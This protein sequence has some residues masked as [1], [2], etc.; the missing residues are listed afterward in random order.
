[1]RYIFIALF[2]VFLGCVETDFKFDKNEWMKISNQQDRDIRDYRLHRIADQIVRSNFLVGKDR[3]EV[4][5]L[6][7]SGSSRGKPNRL[8]YPLGPERGLGVD[9][10]WLEVNFEK[11]KVISSRVVRY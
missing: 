3:E 1:M 11:D 7:G 10:E 9:Y 5:S 6:L 4:S 8:L 2:L